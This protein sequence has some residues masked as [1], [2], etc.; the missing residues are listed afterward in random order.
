MAALYDTI[1]RDYRRHRRPDPR[2]GE[3]VLRGL[4][5]AR[6]VVMW[7]GRRIL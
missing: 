5:D 1:G 2:I 3:A 4:A 6:T 7:G